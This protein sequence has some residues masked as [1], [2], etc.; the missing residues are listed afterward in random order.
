[1]TSDKRSRF[2]GAAILF[3]GS[4]NAEATVAETITTKIVLD[5]DL[6]Q[7][8]HD[9]G[10]RPCKA[11]PLGLLPELWPFDAL[12]RPLLEHAKEF[13]RQVGGHGYQSL[14]NVEQFLVWGP[15]SEKV[16]DIAPWVPEEGNHLITNPRTAQRVWGYQGD[17]FNWERGCAFL[18]QGTFTRHARHGHVDADTGRIYV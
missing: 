2:A 6:V 9:A 15:Y 14:T 12:K 3:D 8:V 17:E 4:G 7:A 18:I 16:G 5:H 11:E 13:V 10:G 1:M